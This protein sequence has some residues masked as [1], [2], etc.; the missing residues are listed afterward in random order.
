MPL[1]TVEKVPGPWRLIRHSTADNTLSF[2]R[3]RP[4]LGPRVFEKAKISAAEV[5]VALF[6][7]DA[8]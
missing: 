2:T 8:V 5:V 1:Q 3:A 7:R 4:D 6:P